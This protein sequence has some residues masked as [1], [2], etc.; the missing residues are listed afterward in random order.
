MPELRLGLNDKFLYEHQGRSKAGGIELEDVKLHQCVRLF[1]FER[2]RTISFVP[3]DGQFELMSY[4]INSVGKPPISV[5]CSA[6][7]WKHS[8]ME[9]IV[10]AH[11]NFKCRSTAVNVI[12][13]IPVAHDVDSP[14][15]RLTVGSAKYVPEQNKMVWSIKLFPGGKEYLLLASFKL[16]SV[17]SEEEDS[18][19]P[20]TVRF[21]I[22]YY[23][24]SGIQVRYLRIVE[25]SGYHALP[26]VRYITQH[27]E[28]ALRMK[29][30]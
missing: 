22:P 26:W 3:P 15:F 11:S 28:Y 7:K 17:V 29:S 5:E 25:K 1:N 21:E 12:I 19:P 18:W 14:T 8:R 6:D 23:T 16:P 24:A 13:E 27:G 2:D 9:Y 10:K 20:V 30:V 4:R